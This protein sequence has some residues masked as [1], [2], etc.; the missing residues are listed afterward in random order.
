MV[1]DGM[2][3]SSKEQSDKSWRPQCNAKHGTGH[4]RQDRF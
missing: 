4:L 1:G 2:G 3:L